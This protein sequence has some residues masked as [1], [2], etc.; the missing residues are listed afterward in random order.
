M[1]RALQWTGWVLAWLVAP[2]C[3]VWAFGALL[4]D[5]PVMKAAVAWIFALAMLAAIFFTRGAW[6]NSARQ[7]SASRLCVH[8]GSH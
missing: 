6:R 1:K 8:G 7:F 5:F 4:Y 3:A 2:G